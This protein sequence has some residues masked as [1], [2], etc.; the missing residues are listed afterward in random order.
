VHRPTYG[1]TKPVGTHHLVRLQTHEYAPIARDVRR[2]SAPRDK[3]RHL[4]G[5]PGW[6]P[7][8]PAPE[9]VR[10]DRSR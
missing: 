1:L 5:P 9:P 4:F 3:L 2:A 7:A 10:A 6:T 8:A